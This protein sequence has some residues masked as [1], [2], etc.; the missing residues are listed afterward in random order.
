MHA[1]KEIERVLTRVFVEA[2]ELLQQILGSEAE[3]LQV[4]V[5]PK[6]SGRHIRRFSCDH[7]DWDGGRGLRG[8]GFVDKGLD[9][10]EALRGGG[11]G[12]ESLAP[13]LGRVGLRMRDRCRGGDRESREGCRDRVYGHGRRRGVKE[14]G[15]RRGC[16]KGTGMTRKDCV[17]VA[18]RVGALRARLDSFGGRCYQ[19]P[20]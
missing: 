14:S 17:L 11:A 12:L 19:M 9:Q 3:F 5:L 2:E 8:L 1:F 4:Q 16:A 13:G 18:C 20:R 7:E 6:Y 15:G 10:L